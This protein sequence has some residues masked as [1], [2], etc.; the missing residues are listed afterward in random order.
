M[1]ETKF[2]HHSLQPEKCLLEKKG[3]YCILFPENYECATIFY[4][5]STILSRIPVKAIVNMA[6]ILL[7]LAEIL[8]IKYLSTCL[9]FCGSSISSIYSVCVFYNIIKPLLHLS[10]TN[11]Y[12][13]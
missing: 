11:L 4:L 9:K 8:E 12:K 5:S 2:T 3:I 7:I 10:V 6:I 13:I 1:L